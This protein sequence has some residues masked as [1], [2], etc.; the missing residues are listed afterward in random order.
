MTDFSK[1]LIG[2]LLMIGG[3]AWLGWALHNAWEPLLYIYLALLV[4]RLGQVIMKD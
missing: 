4:I 3:A 2:C 1:N